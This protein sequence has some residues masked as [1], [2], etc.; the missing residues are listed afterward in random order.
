MALPG[1]AFDVVD[2]D[3]ASI[4]RGSVGYLL[5]TAPFPTLARSIWGDP[6]RYRTQYFSGF[7]PDRYDTADAALLDEDDHLRVVGRADGLINVAG[8]RLSTME[9][10]GALLLVDAVAE[11]AVVGVPDETRG[12]VPI[13]FV[14]LARGSTT[15]TRPSSLRHSSAR[16]ARSP[17][18]RRSTSCRRCRAPVRARSCDVSW[19]SS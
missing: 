6:G 8:H 9:M 19:P 10:E 11:A 4:G 7:G 13:T 18:L 3:G 12:Q 2:D 15:S 14:T 17:A 16:S 5:L 1:H